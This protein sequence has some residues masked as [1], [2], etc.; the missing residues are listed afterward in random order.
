MRRSLRRL[1]HQLSIVGFSLVFGI[2]QALAVL[3]V[4]NLTVQN[5]YVAPPT[6]CSLALPACQALVSV[7]QPGT[8]F[9]LNSSGTLTAAPANTPRFD[10]E[11][12]GSAFAFKGLMTEEAATN[13]APNSGTL[14]VSS[15]PLTNATA[16]YGVAGPD[17]AL[18]AT[19]LNQ[20]TANGQHYVADVTLTVGTNNVGIC[21]WYVQAGTNVTL[22]TVGVGASNYGNSVFNIVTGTKVSDNAGNVSGIQKLANN[23]YR[24]WAARVSGIGNFVCQVQMGDGTNFTGATGNYMTVAYPQ[25]ESIPSI[26]PNLLSSLMGP[27]SP[28]ITGASAVSSIADLAT[29]AGSGPLTADF[30]LYPSGISNRMVVSPETRGFAGRAFASSLCIYGP[31]TKFSYVYAQLTPNAP[32]AGA[33]QNPTTFAADTFA[34]SAGTDV[35]GRVTPV[36]GKTWQVTQPNE[37]EL[38]GAGNLYSFSLAAAPQA[39]FDAGVADYVLTANAKP[40]CAGTSPAALPSIIFRW[41]GPGNYWALQFDCRSNTSAELVEYVNGTAVYSAGSTKAAITSGSFVAVAIQCYG[42]NITIFL[43]GVE[44]FTYVST[45]YES[46]TGVGVQ[47]WAVGSPGSNYAYVNSFA[48]NN[49][50]G[51]LAFNWPIFTEVSLTTPQI[52][53]GPAYATSDVNNAE[54]YY[55]SFN[56]YWVLIYSCYATATGGNNQNYCY[57]TSPSPDG[58]WTNFSGNP[59]ALYSAGTGGPAGSGWNAGA[60]A[61]NGGLTRSSDGSLWST[62]YGCV[63][64]QAVCGATAPFN[65]ASSIGGT[66]TLNGQLFTNP[67]WASARSQDAWIARNALGTYELWVAGVATNIGFG[68]FTSANG[69]SGFTAD[70]NNPLLIGL[71][72]SNDN[73]I[74]FNA[75]GEPVQISNADTKIMMLAYD[76]TPWLGNAYNP[77]AYARAENAS[78]STDNGKTWHHRIK[79]LYPQGSGFMSQQVCDAT[80]LWDGVN[81]L[82]AWHS[83]SNSLSGATLAINLQIGLAKASWNGVFYGITNH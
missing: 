50:M 19:R 4:Q 79:M 24:I 45:D 17:G 13:V 80:L 25:Q 28:I 42:P 35:A 74:S 62:A 68:R 11:W 48:I 39:V 65:N 77:S 1:M 37:I 43:N 12:N 73:G 8:M 60:A 21:S 27:S 26:G 47:F 59:F 34:G 7:T 72:Y 70:P 82:R 16:T 3:P 10:Y 30:T 2:A 20:T 31:Q 69:Y 38:D 76:S 83:S 81:T 15:W 75:L 40:Y 51:R 23:W 41:R 46:A 57:A 52:A 22:A 64:G 66:W 33:Q 58:P 78:I 54:P 14:A 49:T 32:C 71:E 5:A 9:Y 29:F 55:D 44:A 53:I 18:N 56:G 6:Q 61:F 67:S 36:G 63:S